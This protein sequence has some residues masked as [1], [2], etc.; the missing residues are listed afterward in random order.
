[1]GGEDFLKAYEKAVESQY[2]EV[3]T[4]STLAQAIIK[5]INDEGFV[6]DSEISKV[7]VRL[8]EVAEDLSGG[9]A[10]QDKSFPAHPNKLIRHLNRIKP[11]LAGFGISYEITGHTRT[12]NKIGFKKGS[13][14]NCPDGPDVCSGIKITK[15][16]SIWCETKGVWCWK[17]DPF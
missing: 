2:T 14:S 11:I 4:N 17:A 12:G 15:D 5:L 8:K 9:N 13:G 3:V 10:K 1:M 16:G 6:E 7:Y